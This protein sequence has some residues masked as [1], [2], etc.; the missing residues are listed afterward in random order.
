MNACRITSPGSARRRG[1]FTLIELLVVI[2]IIGI[3]A[4]MLLP[5]LARAREAARRVSCAN[6]LRQM[7]MAFKMYAGEHAE[8]YPTI[9]MNVGEDCSQ[10]NEN[11]L[12]VNGPSIYP[13]Y[14]S[15]ARILVCPSSLTGPDSWKRGDWKRADGPLG[16][17]AE[18]TI[19]PCLLDQ[20]SYFYIG[21]ILN[22][23]TMAEPG[24]G[25]AAE[26]FVKG[27]DR[28]LRGADPER[29]EKNWTYE[30]PF[31]E[32]YETLRLKEGIER[33]M[34]EDINNPSASNISQSSIP[35]MFDR[36]DIDVT[37]FNHVPGGVNALY[38]DGHVEFVKYPGLFPANRAWASAVDKL[39]V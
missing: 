21:F 28:W 26:G 32:T 17:R 13:E 25:D 33:F 1:G 3:L 24:T 30:G 34:I 10:P 19:L 39:G 37:G 27:F 2:G 14:L 7:G 6:N 9:Q 36:I 16:S 23:S 29:F 20:T 35:I 31:G 11:V 8:R 4:G 38:M 18:G 5:G 12:M 15:D 22:G